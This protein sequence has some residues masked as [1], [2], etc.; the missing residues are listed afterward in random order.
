MTTVTT[1]LDVLNSPDWDDVA[2]MAVRWQYG[3]YGDFFTALFQLLARADEI[4]FAKLALGFPAEA[5]A[6]RQWR[7][8]DLAERLRKAGLEI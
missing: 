6:V 2:K 4:N 1:P 3:M 8:T 7:E 5:E